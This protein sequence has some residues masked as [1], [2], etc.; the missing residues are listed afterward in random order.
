MHTS[1]GLSTMIRLT[2]DWD[3]LPHLY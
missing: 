2:Y 3:R 1:F